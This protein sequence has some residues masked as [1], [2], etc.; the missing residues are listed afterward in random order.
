MSFVSFAR[1]DVGWAFLCIP[2][3]AYRCGPRPSSAKLFE[4]EEMFL[5]VRAAP[6]DARPPKA[7][8]KAIPESVLSERSICKCNLLF[9]VSSAGMGIS[10]V[11]YK[12]KTWNRCRLAS[13]PFF[14][15]G[16]DPL[17]PTINA[18]TML[19]KTCAF[20]LCTPL[21]TRRHGGGC[22]QSW[23]KPARPAEAKG[24]AQRVACAGRWRLPCLRV[25]GVLSLALSHSRTLAL[26]LLITHPLHR[27]RARHYKYSVRLARASQPRDFRAARG[28]EESIEAAKSESPVLQVQ[29]RQANTRR[30]RG[31]WGGMRNI[32]N[33]DKRRKGEWK[34]RYKRYGRG[35]VLRQE[36]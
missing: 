9:D 28:Q 34:G 30:K 12:H 14:P 29:Q 27:T 18:E 24:I 6:F 23:S 17:P 4:F 15:F 31:A 3:L 1:L 25:R 8:K 36:G 13:S 2:S 26:S 16:V 22:T 21:E 32:D 33:D 10:I 35:G 7:A 11:R 5:V 19:D 20:L